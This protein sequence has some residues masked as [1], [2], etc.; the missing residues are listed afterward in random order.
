[1]ASRN[2]KRP[3]VPP[4][5]QNPMA[6]SG[7]VIQINHCR[8]PDCDNYGVPARISP[9]RTG[10]PSDRDPHYKVVT[11]NK[12]RF[13]ALVCKYCGEKPPIKSNQGIAEELAW[14][15]APLFEDD[16]G[17]P[18]SGCEN[19][20]KRTDEHPELY[21]R[22]GVNS[23]T[24]RERRQCRCCGHRFDIGMAP[25]L[26]HPSNHHLAS[27]VFNRVVNKSP[28]R[29]TLQGAGLTGRPK[30]YY[31][32]VRF[33]QRRCNHLNGGLERGMLRGRV[34]LPANL[35]LVTDMQQYQLNWTNRLDKRNPMFSAVCTVDRDSR[36]IFGMHANYDPDAD[37][38]AIAK[39]S[40]ERGDLEQPE[41]FRRHGRLWLPGDELMGGRVAG[42]RMGLDK[43]R[44]LQKQLTAIYASAVR[45]ADVEDRE[46]QEIHPGLHNPQAGTGLQVGYS[47]DCESLLRGAFLSA[48]CDEVKQGTA[49]GFYVRHKKYLTVTERE[50]AKKGSPGAFGGLSGRFAGRSA[51]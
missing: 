48:W 38:F 15:S 8:M 40:P 44:A 20:G 50:T 26:V 45:R 14:L 28:V 11:T 33:I 25:P 17:C 29:R 27:A 1:M 9:V 49:H 30:Q 46:L 39:E 32:L 47:M 12:G 31:G 22:Y 21:R 43:V 37:A 34:P 24:E 41:A 23:G 6:V 51:A 7:S 13:P 36:Y 10:R 4:D 2:T 18:S 3:R 16:Q 5:V 35:H 42:E 19:N